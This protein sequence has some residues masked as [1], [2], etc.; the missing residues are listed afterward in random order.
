MHVPWRAGAPGSARNPQA[1][2]SR[3]TA[4][5]AG[6]R[7]PRTCDTGGGRPQGFYISLS[8]SNKVINL[9]YVDDEPDLLDLGKLFLERDGEFSVSTAA[10]ADLALSMLASAPVDAV[11]SDYQMPGMDGLAFLKQVRELHN[12][13]PF[14]LFTGKG[15]EEV[16]IEAINN[17]ADFYIQK[18]GEPRAQ[19]T[20]LIHKIRQAVRRKNAEDDLRRAYEK[21]KG[22]MDHANDAIF[23][24]DIGTGMLIDANRKAL[25]LVGKELAEIRTMRQDDLHPASAAGGE[26]GTM[27]NHARDRKGIWE[28]LVIDG[29]G[30]PVPV[31]VS[32]TS[33]DVGGRRCLMS[34]YHDI[35]EI[36]KTQDALQL[37]NR[38]LN[39]LAEVTRHDIRN[40]LTVL[41]GY[42]ELFREHPPEPQHSMYLAKV[43]DTVATIGST[44]EFTRLYQNLGVTS[45]D[46]QDVDSVFV[47]AC[48]MADVKKV[49]LYSEVEGIS[50][51]ADPLLEKVFY[52]LVEN[53][54]THGERIR[55]IRMTAREEPDELVIRFEDDGIG[56]PDHDKERIFTRGFGKNTGLG[57][58]LAREI[59]STTGITIRETGVYQEGARFEIHVPK[60]AYHRVH[61][62][63]SKAVRRAA[64]LRAEN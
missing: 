3:S 15:R 34:I 46:W 29:S 38:K 10:S 19:F 63:L 45:P 54:I 13:L 26:A 12:D 21:N 64:R 18:G 42:I 61:H 52:N 51:F 33:I 49:R 30:R 14:I 4:G 36:K 8:D 55:E 37:A 32:A 44:I 53:A 27:G 56:I 31:M 2:R 23:I 24:A 41:G 50:I 48:T 59:L 43:R 17:G 39:L 57:L 1:G 58:F 9:L 25:E 20:E 35:S 16:V 40:K 47:R 11:I 5:S 6:A 62:G 22:L 7:K 28:E 60:G